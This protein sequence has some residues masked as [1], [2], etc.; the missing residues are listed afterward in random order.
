MQEGVAKQMGIAKGIAYAS[1]QL[2]KQY[3]TV[4]LCHSLIPTVEWRVTSYSI[5]KLVFPLAV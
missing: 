5:N 2:S 3:F 4:V 1:F